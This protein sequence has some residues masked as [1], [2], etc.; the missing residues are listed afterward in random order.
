MNPPMI[1]PWL[2]K[3]WGVSQERTLE[4]WQ[5]AYSDAEETPGAARNSEFWARAQARWIDHLDQ[6]VLARHPVAE[7]PWVMIHLNLLRL[8]ASIRCYFNVR[9]P[10]FSTY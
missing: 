4:L 6:E 1:L 2:A 5:H 8:L 10:Q 9:M 7:T 3:K